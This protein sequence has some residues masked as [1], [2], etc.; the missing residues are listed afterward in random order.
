MKSNESFLFEGKTKQEAIEK[1]CKELNLPEESL[2]I[3]VLEQGSSGIF[4]IVR[5]KKTKIRV[6]IK[7]DVWAKK[8]ISIAK[9]VLE[10]IFKFFQLNSLSIKE[11][12]QDK[13]VSLK[14]LGDNSCG[15][16]IGKGGRTLDA[17]EFI[18]NKI[19]NKKLQKDIRVTL[20]IQ[21]Y[22]ERRRE[23]LK[24]IA[25][26]MAEKVKK[27]GKALSTDPLSPRDRRII[28]LTLKD[29]KLLETK[30]KGEGLFRKVIII[31]KN[32]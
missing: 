25:I 11:D 17:L 28:H 13:V 16:L 14:V 19:V 5:G 1:A 6:K 27:T 9:E 18:I 2:E 7:E 8:S 26:S 31:P 15:I 20:D 23:Y 12:I 24:K 3:E 29:D 22:R 10:E 30:T 21:G 4:G 32:K